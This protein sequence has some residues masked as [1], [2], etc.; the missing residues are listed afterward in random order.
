MCYLQIGWRVHGSI[1][2]AL[3]SNEGVKKNFSF[4]AS[5]VKWV[6]PKVV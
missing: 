5:G 2:S 6:M 3:P 1:A 4:D